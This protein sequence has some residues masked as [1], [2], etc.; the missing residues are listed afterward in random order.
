[1]KIQDIEIDWLGHSAFKIKT[2]KKIIFIDPFQ[3]SDEDKA[4]LILITHSHY[5]HCS[6]QDIDKIAKDGTIIICTADSQSKINRIQKKIE[7]VLVEPEKEVAFSD[8]KIKAVNAY[9]NNKPFHPK[10]EYWVGYVILC[11]KTAVYHAGDTDFIKEMS[12]LEEYSKKYYLIAL[13]PVDGKFNMNSQDALKAATAIKPALAI[14]MHYAS[15]AGTEADAKKFVE[16]CQEKGINA[17]LLD[18]M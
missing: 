2:N 15:I 13:L 12:S 7:I 17:E 18:K 11:G 5:D 16:L 1:M 14:P 3:I 10:S 4:D 6:Y 9:N 8:I